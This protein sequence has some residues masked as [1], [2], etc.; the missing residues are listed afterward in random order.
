MPEVTVGQQPLPCEG[1]HYDTTPLELSHVNGGLHDIWLRAISI[2]WNDATNLKS[3][4]KNQDGEWV[5]IL[6]ED[7]D[8]EPL[9]PSFADFLIA[10]PVVA[11]TQF[12]FTNPDRGTKALNQHALYV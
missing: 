5:Q 9:Y 7:Q 2:V 11:L 4:G 8:I 10:E 3:W 6:S 1:E 12:G